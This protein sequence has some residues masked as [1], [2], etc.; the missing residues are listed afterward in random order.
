[1]LLLLGTGA[2]NMRT[3]RALS[4][5]L[6]V[7]M[8]VST[9]PPAM[10]WSNGGYS[11][12]PTKPDY[13]T[14]DW[15]V[16]HAI[17][18]LPAPEK[19][20]ITQNLSGFLYGTEL[21]DLPS[22]SG[23]IGDT[24][25]HHIYYNKDGTVMHME[26][27]AAWR[28]STE[29]NKTMALLQAGN[30]NN[31]SRNAGTMTHYIGDISVWAHVMGAPTKNTWGTDNATRHSD[32]E[33]HVT[34]DTTTFNSTQWDK[35]L[36]FDYQLDIVTAYNATLALAKNTTF[37]EG[38]KYNCTWMNA[39]AN[40][41]SNPEF[42]NRTGRLLNLA[43]NTVADVLHTLAVES[44]YASGQVKRYGIKINEVETNPPGPDGSKEWVELFNPTKDTADISR[45]Y[46]ETSTVLSWKF[47]DGTVI[48]PGAYLTV[49]TTCPW[50]VDAKETVTLYTPYGVEIDRT[51]WLTDQQD[52]GR[53]WARVPN[54]VDTNSS[55]DWAFQGSTK[56]TTND[57][58]PVPA[59]RPPVSN[60]TV[61]PSEGYTTTRF[62]VDASGSSDPDGDRISH[63]WS[64]GDGSPNG[65]GVK[66]A[67][68]YALPGVYDIVLQV[69]DN[70]GSANS[71]SR[72]VQVWAP[73]P[74]PD[75]PPVINS[76]TVSPDLPTDKDKVT[77]SVSAGDDLGIARVTANYTVVGAQ[78]AG[79]SNTSIDSAP[80]DF[81][82]GPFAKGVSVQFH[83]EAL[84]TGGN[85]VRYP[86]TGELSFSVRP[87]ILPVARLTV[88]S[89][90]ALVG[91]SVAFDGAGSYDLD[92]RVV[93]YWYDVGDGV[94][95]GW[96]DA[97]TA[98]HSYGTPGV[99]QVKLKVRDD[100]LGTNA[101]EATTVTIIKEPT[102]NRPPAISIPDAP[103]VI[104][105]NRTMDLVV[106]STDPDGD[107]VEVYLIGYDD[108]VQ[109]TGGPSTG[110]PW[111]LV[112][113]PREDQA[114]IHEI[115]VEASDG[116]ANAAYRF[117]VIV[118]PSGKPPVTKPHGSSNGPPLWVYA[119]IAVIIIVLVVVIAYIIYTRTGRRHKKHRRR[120][121]R[122]RHGRH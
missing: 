45:W 34:G 38:G 39:T 95:A 101:A 88:S 1:M 80:Y 52:D 11:A 99:Y 118:E 19:N 16:E 113:T 57:L 10:A 119:L 75:M 117:T 115:G 3:M 93:K 77:L 122:S 96:Q 61:S 37:G 91:Q 82:L 66:A 12:D 14:H 111:H 47:I 55:A 6:T 120:H 63:T 28:A 58:P 60:F 2:N 110:R 7:V 67:H 8:L 21:P 78:P 25:Y 35:F 13:G 116:R 4:C 51:P 50:L 33:T 15:I 72:T 68:I 43:V 17:A 105:A 100:D 76:V 32:Y 31:A 97:G 26:D 23:G 74:G 24:W 44:G 79:W 65:T 73:K 89:T 94:S 98:V 18:W 29:Y 102:V 103:A 104:K 109:L 56:N 40:N 87:N 106:D 59:D 90:R 54:G 114:G 62:I 22:G 86:T 108:G 71:S 9:L 49:D 41:W 64:W 70:N 83:I 85:M 27:D 53:T 121:H 30:L 69:D 48:G 46:F 42:V 5:L 81:H 112:W 36:F 20:Y 84:D 107:T 92:G